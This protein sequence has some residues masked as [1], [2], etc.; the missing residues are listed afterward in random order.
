MAGTPARRRYCRVGDGLAMLG[1]QSIERG[2]RLR[3]KPVATAAALSFTPN[4]A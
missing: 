4:L 1:S 3:S 2:R